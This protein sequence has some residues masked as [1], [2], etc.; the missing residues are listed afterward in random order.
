MQIK[1]FVTFNSLAGAPLVG[2]E[3]TAQDN[4]NLLAIREGETLELCVVLL[5]GSLASETVIQIF[6]NGVLE[7]FRKRATQAI[8][9]QL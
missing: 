2:F 8:G 4:G 7:D 9:K 1:Y 5:S 3:R 6:T